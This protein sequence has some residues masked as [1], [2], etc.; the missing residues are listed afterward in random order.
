MS[1]SLQYHFVSQ[2]ASTFNILVVT[3]LSLAILSSIYDSDVTAALA[4]MGIIA[5]LNYNVGLL[6]LVSHPDKSHSSLQF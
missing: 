6:F 4:V 2:T 5:I 3:H 1:S